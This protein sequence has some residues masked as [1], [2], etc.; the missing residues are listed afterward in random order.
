MKSKEEI[1]LRKILKI[2]EL[3]FIAI[4]IVTVLVVFGIL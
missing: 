1:M 3:G 4:G 2:F